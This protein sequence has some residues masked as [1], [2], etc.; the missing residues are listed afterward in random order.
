MALWEVRVSERCPGVDFEVVATDADPRMLERARRGVYGAGSIRELPSD[1]RRHTFEG[2]CEPY[3]VRDRLRERVSWRCQDVRE[4]TP[5]GPF[6]V[7]L[8]RNLALTYFVE[9]LQLE[10]MGRVARVLRRGGALVIGSH[11]SLPRDDLGFVPWSGPQPI[12]RLVE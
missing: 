3:R 9:A 5:A 7:V 8:C 11:E 6:D 4:T 1:L 12:Y 10:V 2:E